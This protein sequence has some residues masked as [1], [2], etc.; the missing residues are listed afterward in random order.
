MTRPE[1]SSGYRTAGRLAFLSDEAGAQ[2]R[3]ILLEGCLALVT[4]PEP[5]SSC[6]KAEELAPV[7]FPEVVSL[8]FFPQGCLLKVFA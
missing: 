2:L 3:F 8:R 5:G 6:R 7:V 1:L 4:R